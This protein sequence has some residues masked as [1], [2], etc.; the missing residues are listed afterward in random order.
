LGGDHSA[1]YLQRIAYQ[2]HRQNRHV[3]RVDLRGSGK[4]L[5]LA[6]RP[7]HAGRS[8]DLVAVVSQAR[9]LLP[10]SPIQIV[11]FSLSGNI[12]LKMLGEMSAGLHSLSLADSNIRQALAIAP[13]LNLHACADNMDRLSRRLYSYYYVKN[14]ER[15]VDLKRSLW[16]QWRERPTEPPIRTIRQFDERYTAPLGGFENTSHYYTDASSIH[17]LAQVKTPTEI[18]LDRDDPIVNWHSHLDAQYD[19]QWVRLTYTSYGGHMGY[20]G[21]DDQNRLIRWME[22]YV[23]H[24]MV[25]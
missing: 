19:P 14:L 6:W 23:I 12:L 7:A 21:L 13:P 15:Q 3:W 4:G 18:L 17:W 2:L 24:Q 8:S 16:P 11:G 5:E 22:H 20:F 9:K 1:P 25:S 10:D